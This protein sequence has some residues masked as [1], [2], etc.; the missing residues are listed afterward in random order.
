M[1]GKP[2]PLNSRSFGGRITGVLLEEEVDRGFS[3]SR[4]LGNPLHVNINLFPEL[5][6]L[7]V[8]VI[9]KLICGHG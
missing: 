6:E 2:L 9:R 1:C 3:P 8:L 5:N 4:E 7:E